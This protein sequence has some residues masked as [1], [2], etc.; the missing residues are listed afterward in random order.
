MGLVVLNRLKA[1][2][3]G[4]AA[5]LL[6]VAGGA[7]AQTRYALDVTGARAEALSKVLREASTLKAGLDEGIEDPREVL[8]LAQ[9]EYLALLEA[10]YSKGYYSAVIEVKL[11]GREAAQIGPFAV[12][13]A[14]GQ[15]QVRVRLGPRFL[16]GRARIAPVR[17]ASDI[18][19]GFRSGAP[20]EADVVRAAA[21]S[22]VTGWREAGYAKATVGAQTVS[23]HHPSAALNVDIAVEQ[24]P[25]V[26]FGAAHVRG[27]SAVRAARVRKIAGLPRGE[28]YSPAAVDKAELRLRRTGTFR[29]A[30]IAQAERVN[31]DGTLDFDITVTDRKPRR[32]GFGAELSSI[33]G[34]KLSG[35]WL[36]RNILGG[37]ERL[38]I[39]GEVSQIGRKDDGINYALTARF[40]KPAAFGPDT[41]GFAEGELIYAD[42]PSYVSKSAR[43]MAGL[44]HEFDKGLVG[45]LGLA[46]EYSRVRYTGGEDRFVLFSM[47]LGLTR[48]R[49][50]DTLDPKAGT[51]LKA[52]LEPFYEFD[53]GNAGAQLKLDARAYRAFGRGVLAGRFQLGSLV[54]AEA[55]EVPP[56]YLFLS[57]GSG[58]VRGQP[59]NSLG[60]DDGGTLIGGRSFAALSAELRVAVSERIGVVGFADAGYISPESG[61]GGA[62]EWHSG[63]GLGLRYATPIGPVRLDVAA[64]VSGTTGDGVQV[65]IGIGQSF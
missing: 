38:R 64:P 65:Y 8:A 12:P 21:S 45:E 61:L 15:A 5:A 39:G 20:A 6:L 1:C 11:D 63:A 37:A 25:K 46:L 7:G 36:H 33:D 2:A 56:D 14:I 55:G 59:Y 53:G 34:A 26:R 49:R 13:A 27:Q 50:D 47:P 62:G 18:P 52:G 16:F 28:T 43:L 60:V 4:L 19:E 23:A 35:F 44:S 10:L 48:D 9:G 42:E 41:L 57:G 3:A 22:V 30:A 31:A 51:Y 29:T 40:E 54:G 32:V 17:A 24:G 58:S